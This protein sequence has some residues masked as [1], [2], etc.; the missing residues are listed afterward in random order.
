MVRLQL[1]ESPALLVGTSEHREERKSLEPGDASRYAMRVTPVD[2]LIGDGPDERSS[3][4]PRKAMTTILVGNQ[5]EK[6]DLDETLRTPQQL[7]V[8]KELIARDDFDFACMNPFEDP[9][10]E[11]HGY[12]G[13]FVF[14]WYTKDGKMNARRIGK[15]GRTLYE[16]VL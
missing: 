10:N 3:A 9:Y 7:A 16:S 1:C 6:H 13:P 8:V 14:I 4:K 12:T 2:R 5:Y 11:L 15:R